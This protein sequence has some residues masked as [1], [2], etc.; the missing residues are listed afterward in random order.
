MFGE[1]NLSEF[2]LQSDGEEDDEEKEEVSVYWTSTHRL[3]VRD[4]VLIT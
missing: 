3:L 2:G 4:L 1:F